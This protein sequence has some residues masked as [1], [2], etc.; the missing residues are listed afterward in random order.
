MLDRR[1]L[2]L[3]GTAAAG[4]APLPALALGGP[5]TARDAFIF[6]FP[7]YEMYRTRQ[8]ALGAQRPMPPN[9]FAHRRMLTDDRSREVTTPNNDTLYSSAWLDL[10]GGALLLSLP[11]TG[12]RYYSAALMDMYTNNFAC[13]GRRTTGTKA[14]DVVIAGPGWQGEAPAGLKI[15]RSPTPW[16]WALC[17]FLVDGSDDLPAVHA[18]QDKCLL[19]PLTRGGGLNYTAPGEAPPADKPTDPAV[20]VPLVNRL[21][22]ENPPPARDNT[23]LARF[24][25]VGVRPDASGAGLSL[26]DRGIW[27]A[28]LLS[29]RSAMKDVGAAAG[30]PVDGWIRPP[31]EIGNFGD[32]YMLRAIVALI[33]LGALEQAEAVYMSANVDIDGAALDGANRYR[34]RLGPNDLPPVDAFWSLSMYELTSDGRAFFTRNPIGRYAIGDRTQGLSRGADGALEIAIQREAPEGALRANW[35]PT[36]AGPFRLT[37]RAYQPKPAMLDGSYRPP[38]VSRLA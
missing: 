19:T 32:D 10:R 37:L 25:D 30:R 1:R 27:Y 7:L 2:M 23:A 35:L 14:L 26:I 3:A 31:R 38:G 24:G 5:G 9:M 16:A 20:Y 17:R 18:L 11:D 21:L 29:A 33:G 22:A 13:L 6:T 15:I 4:L 34:L 28:G 12:D 36:P 8:I